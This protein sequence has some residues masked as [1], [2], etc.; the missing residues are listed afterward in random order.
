MTAA[1]SSGVPTRPSGIDCTIASPLAAISAEVM[2][3]SI[4]PGH[5]AFTVMC[6]ASSLASP[7]V[8]PSTPAFEAL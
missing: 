5:T 8:R 4:D 3:V 2:P 7:R 6:G 1:T